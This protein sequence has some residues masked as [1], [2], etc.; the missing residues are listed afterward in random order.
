MKKV[1]DK[2]LLKYLLAFYIGFFLLSIVSGALGK[3]ENS[4]YSSYTWAEFFS[5]NVVR[6]S[7]K[8]VFILGAIYF[9]RYLEV[10]HGLSRWSIYCLHIVFGITLT[11][12]SVTSQVIVNNWLYNSNDPL[13]FKYVYTGALLGTDYNFFLY[14]SMAVIVIAYYFFQKQKDY[15]V[16]ENELKTQL[17]NSQIKALQ[18]QLQPHFL[19]NTLNDI[20]S[21]IDIEPEKAQDAIS[22]LSDLL[23]E[24]LKFK[25]EKFVTV[26]EELTILK[27]YLGIEKLRFSDK[28]VFNVQ[29]PEK[30]YQR[31]IPP[32]L[33]QPFVENSI[34]HGFSLENDTLKVD[35][36]LSENE[37]QL[38]IVIA[39]NGT[40]L[41]NT[42]TILYGTGLSNVL[43]RLETIYESNFHFEIKNNSKSNGVV[44]QIVIPI[45]G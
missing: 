41:K 5:I 11:F 29:I 10:K 45:Q 34:K 44:V 19:F 15:Q 24:T 4:A 42:E 8:L 38:S 13:T 33:L 12:Y 14:F 18:S 39:N 20:S 2:Q 35:I 21:L 23:R 3:I 9:M 22:D 31:K 28:V 1:I 37:N 40:P 32:L 6:Y 36:L 25:D 7:L 16:K 27:K 17:L 30:I 26:A 43:S